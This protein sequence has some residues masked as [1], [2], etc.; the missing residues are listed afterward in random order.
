MQEF[1]VFYHSFI[2]NFIFTK[3]L[4][5]NLLV[6]NVGS[7]A[8]PSKMLDLGLVEISWGCVLFLFIAPAEFYHNSFPNP[9]EVRLTFT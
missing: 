8:L 5:I 3:R 2:L 6:K 7:G 4:N 9:A 1:L